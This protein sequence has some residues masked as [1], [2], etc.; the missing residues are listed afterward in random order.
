MSETVYM[1]CSF[2]DPNLPK[3]TQFLGVCVLEM[4]SDAGPV[5][6]SVKAHALGINPGGEL[7]T[8]PFARGLI[9]ESWLN[10]FIPRDEVFRIEAADVW[11]LK[12]VVQ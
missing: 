1:W 8:V 3:G 5:L 10:I 12:R 6:A 2:A 9:H 4:P 11:H 7:L